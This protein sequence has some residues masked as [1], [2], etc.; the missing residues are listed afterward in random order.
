MKGARM[1]RKGKGRKEAGERE[2]GRKEGRKE[3]RKEGRN[4]GRKEGRK[5]GKSAKSVTIKVELIN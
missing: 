1:E 5:E 2:E 3:V 4:E